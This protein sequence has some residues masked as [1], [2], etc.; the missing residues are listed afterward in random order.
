LVDVVVM[1]KKGKYVRDLKQD[2]FRVFEDN[3]QQQVSSF[4]FG[5]DPAAPAAAQKRYLVLVFDNST[6]D[7]SDQA[8]A[9]E[10]A[11][12]F[13]DANAGPDRLM[14]VVDFGG[15]LRIAQ[16]FTA[17]ADRLKQV[18][19]A[20][21]V[22]S[23]P[24][25]SAPPVEVAS[26]GSPQLS[27]VEADFGARSLL[28]AIRSLAKSLSAVPGRKS[29]V[30]FSA[31]FELTPDRQY[32]L[33]ATIDA[34]NRA[35]VAIYPLDARGL[36]TTMPG[37]RNGAALHPRNG[38]RPRKFDV[39]HR[40]P[41]TSHGTPRLVLASFP[42]AFSPDPQRPAPEGGGRG[43]GG[44][45]PI[46]PGGGGGGGRGGTGGGTGGSGGTG[47]G[48]GG[49]GGTGGRPPGG[50]PPGG[51]PPTR[52]PVGGPNIPRSGFNNYDRQP[53]IL[54]PELP[55]SAST[56][57]Q[58]LY[59]LAEG[60]GG[61]PIL[62]TND[63]LAGLERIG[64][65]QNEFYILGY[66]PPESEEGSCHALK[67]K[68]EHGGGLHVRARSGY[69]NSRVV[70]PLAGKPIEKELESR[71]AAPQAGNIKGVMR[72]PF[73]Y[74]G[75][76][77]ARVNLTMDLPPQSLNFS[78][79]KGKYRATINVLGIAYRPDGTIGARFS[80]AVKL[81]LE[82]DEWKE[83]Q[84]TPFHYENQFGVA[85]GQYK[86]TVVLSEGGESF[87][88]YESP[89]VIEP[90]DGKQL[91]LSAV[92]MSNSMQRVADLGTGMDAALLEDRTPLVVR[93]MQITP[94]ATNHFKRNDKVGLYAEIYEP[95]QATDKP[96]ELL[97]G[98]RVVDLRDGKILL[99]SG[100]VETKGFVQKGNPVVPIGLKVPLKDLP[101][102]SYR[103]EMQAWT[104]SNRSEIRA[105]DFSVEK[106]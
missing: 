89:L 10:A 80:D 37:R 8:R 4:S 64:Q 95:S 83:L 60:T 86:L 67:V 25:P 72:T 7:I 9:R 103:L 50:S 94:S 6:M 16:N 35:N 65:E 53:R 5:A 43:G 18:V 57:Q 66:V 15:T 82:K 58:V 102:G 78:K 106:D 22:P 87:G 33:T 2:D 39:R 24:S 55:P 99:S 17:N 71:A 45:P 105:T 34:C 38:I 42:V 20:V 52:G 12:K 91:A 69:C 59:A 28:L 73:F 79:E 13:I 51:T 68:L 41:A 47:G 101:P 31:G 104:A 19:A 90:F 77:T 61:F 74:T 46:G 36:V 96:V 76:D 30:L 3:K 84:K 44:G 27:T 98:Y 93:G 70:N 85:P 100:E 75:P 62:N 26:L 56:N 54:V 97:V 88:R 14:A 32:E 11:A 21:K 23:G 48:T 1:D 81:E 29:V 63:L 49:T 40:A 92:A